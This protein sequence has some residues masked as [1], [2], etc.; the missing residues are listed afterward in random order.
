[1]KPTDEYK[2]GSLEEAEEFAKKRN[3]TAETIRQQAEKIK[4]MEIWEKKYLDHIKELEAERDYIKREWIEGLV[5]ITV[6]ERAQELKELSNEEIKQIW[7][8]LYPLSSSSYW[9]DKREGLAE[10]KFA[11]AILKKASEK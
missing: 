9:D 3:Q 4:N 1:M 7:Y 10:L 8:S 5:K 6:L 11:R 2:L